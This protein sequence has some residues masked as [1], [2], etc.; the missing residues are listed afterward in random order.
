M[1]PL[2]D[3]PGVIRVRL[4]GALG[5]LADVG[6][7]FFVK[8]SGTPPTNAELLTWATAIGT[9]WATDIAPL[10]NADYTLTGVVCEDLTTTSSAIADAVVSHVG[11]R[12]GTATT[13][14]AC[15]VVNYDIARRYRG[16]HPRS[17]W[18]MGVE[19]DIATVQEWGGSFITAVDSGVA[20]FLTAVF[21]AGWSGAG[22]LDQVSVGYYGPTVAYPRGFIPVT[23]PVTGRTRDVPATLPVANVDTVIAVA[24]RTRIGSQR[25]RLL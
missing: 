5:D 22:T 21:G 13:A 24:A 17:Y 2:P 6:T 23:N 7:R 3:V 19:A 18:Y 15:V 25:R 12:S 4:I 20:A 11:T 8:Y 1:P 16:G 14:A 10:V 9:A